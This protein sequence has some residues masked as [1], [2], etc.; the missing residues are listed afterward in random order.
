MHPK[1]EILDMIKWNLSKDFPDIKER[2]EGPP[3]MESLSVGRHTL[4]RV[5]LDK[6]SLN[7]VITYPPGE[8]TAF[9]MTKVDKA[10]REGL[11][12][13]GYLITG[14][15]GTE[16]SVRGYNYIMPSQ[17]EIKAIEEGGYSLSEMNMSV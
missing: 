16:R 4:V 14:V 3:S 9:D 2:E 7:N 13:L 12:D 17:E 15:S 6:G 8:I 1:E 10:V 5:V 11:S